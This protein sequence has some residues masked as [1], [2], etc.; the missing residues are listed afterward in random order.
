MVIYGHMG[1]G[2]VHFNPLRPA[3]QG[4]KEFMAAHCESVSHA[5]DGLVHKLSGSIS[6]EHG[7]GVAKRDDLKQYKSPVELELMW[8]VKQALDPLNLLNPGKMLPS[9]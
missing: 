4:A 1:D 2:N 9:L 6:A 5:V 7:I 8:Q 3:H